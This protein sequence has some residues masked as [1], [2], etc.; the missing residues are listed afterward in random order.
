MT[1]PVLHGKRPRYDQRGIKE[2]DTLYVINDKNLIVSKFQVK[3]IFSNQTFGYMLI[4][5]GNLA[6][7]IRGYRVV[8]IVQDDSSRYAYIN[9]ARGDYFIKTGNR[10]KAVR[11]Y[12]KAIELDRNNPSAH[13]ALGLIYLEDRVNNFAYSELKKSY[14]NIGRLYDNEDKFILLATLAKICYDETYG[15]YNAQKIRVR[16]WEEGKKYC[17]EALRINNKSI[18]THFLLG[19]FYYNALKRTT[20]K[21]KLARNSYLEVVALSPNHKTANYRLARL[22]FRHENKEKGLF[23][24]RKA[25]AADPGNS[26]ARELLKRNQ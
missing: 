14:K 8:Q 18:E 25:I 6:L 26:E 10:G 21:D 11:E 1:C 17:N 23:Y 5:Y 24:V 2:N 4:G 7:S 20:E 16:F 22:Y 15:S 12:K 13:L 9:K 3:Y 19:E